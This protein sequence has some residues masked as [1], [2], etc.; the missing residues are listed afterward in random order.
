MIDVDVDVDVDVDI[1]ISRQ[2]YLRYIQILYVLTLLTM[3]QRW[4]ILIL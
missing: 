2:C 1:N 3:Q 4:N